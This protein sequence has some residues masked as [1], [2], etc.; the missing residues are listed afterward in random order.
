MPEIKI[1]NELSSTDACDPNKQ[2]FTSLHHMMQ[3]LSRSPACAG[4]GF[5][6]PVGTTDCRIKK[7]SWISWPQ[8]WASSANRR[9]SSSRSCC[10][11]WRG[12]TSYWLASNRMMHNNRYATVIFRVVAL[13]MTVQL[14]LGPSTK[15]FWAS[16]NLLVL[17]QVLYRD[18]ARYCSCEHKS[19]DD[20]GP[21]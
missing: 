9:R 10:T 20:A 12:Q 3:W 2:D 7:P 14:A 6:L 16:A 1:R 5:E 8:S 13:F 18:S 15:C 17:F 11:R 4:L 21:A 19:P